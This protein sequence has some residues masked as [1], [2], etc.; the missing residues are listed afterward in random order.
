MNQLTNQ[1]EIYM[2]YPFWAAA[3]AARRCA[4][5]VAFCFCGIAVGH[6]GGATHERST[7]KRH[8]EATSYCAYELGA[9]L[10]AAAIN[11]RNQ[12]TGVSVVAD[13]PQAFVWDFR[14]GTRLIG[15]LPGATDSV[16]NDIN[17]RGQV[18]GSS[19][20][21]PFIW[22]ER[23]GMRTFDTLGGRFSSATHIN[24]AGQIIGLGL[25]PAEDGEHLYFR[26]VNGDVEDL[27][28]WLIPF[29]LTDFGV[30]GFSIQSQQAPP[31]AEMF[32][33]SLRKG[34]QPLRGFPENRLI[35]P[36]AINNR[37]HIVGS[38]YPDDQS[39]HA[40][41]WTPSKGM[42]FLPPLYE[43][44]SSYASDV[45]EWGVV[46]GAGSAG[47]IVPF[48]WTKRSGTRDLTTMLH[49]TS[50]TVPQEQAM[51]A[52]ALNDYGWIA[53][54]A[55]ELGGANPR[56]YVLTPKFQGDLTACAPP[57]PVFGE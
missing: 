9:G 18:V 56:A 48:I 55:S 11:N 28:V 34:V 4:I 15:V 23:N 51:Q 14:R 27:G 26:N 10:I 35:G 16:A 41:R 47:A 44:S 54:N 1:G 40:M 21:D 46:V 7:S 29:G 43:F 17:D 20:G 36:A 31:T 22:D 39:G 30:V 6:A 53:L 52:R 37:L 8:R 24:D 2:Q 32:I 5:T 33:W 19:G 45:N 38:A 42:Q 50:P 3:H 49:P 57:P 12:I 13:F 25:T